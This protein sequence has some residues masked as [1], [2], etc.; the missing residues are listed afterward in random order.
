MH[1]LIAD[2]YKLIEH[3]TIKSLNEIK[4]EEGAKDFVGILTFFRGKVSSRDL[5]IIRCALN[6]RNAHDRGRNVRLLKHDVIFR[7]GERGNTIVN[8]CVRGYFEEQSG[9]TPL[10]CDGDLTKSQCILAPKL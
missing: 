7:Y 10:R 4:L 1:E 3:E 6:V 2:G 5:E 8:L 9:P